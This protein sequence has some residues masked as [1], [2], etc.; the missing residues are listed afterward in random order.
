MTKTISRQ[1]STTNHSPRRQRS[2][3]S[4]ATTTSSAAPRGSSLGSELRQQFD[5]L[6]VDEAGQFSLA[7]TVAAA[8]AAKNLVL[9]GDPQQLDQPIQGT[10]PD[11]AATSALSHIIGS[12]DRT[13]TDDQGIFL[14]DTWRMDAAVCSNS[15]ATPSTTA[16]SNVPPRRRCDTSMVLLRARGGHRSSTP[17]T[18]RVPSEEAERAA[19]IAHQ[20]ARPQLH[21]RRRSPHARCEPDDLMFITPFNAQVGAIQSALRERGIE[22]A[23]VGTVDLFQGRQAPVVIYSL[24]SSSAELAPRGIN[25][26]LSANRFNVAIS[27]AQVAAI[28]LASPALLDTNCT[29]PEQLPLVGALCNFVDGA[30]VLV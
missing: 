22:G 11:G 30:N 27:R 21:R 13:V 14:D 19:D 25:F 4:T 6:V 28:V 9:L 23:Q 18:A 24:T 3:F 8:T 10:H 7:N 15:S 26:L 12:E 20:L 1:V 17:T 16:A 5:V 29:K 2:V